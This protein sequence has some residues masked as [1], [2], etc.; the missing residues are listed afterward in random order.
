MNAE[1]PRRK[2]TAILSADVEGYT[3]LIDDDEN[4]TLQTITAYPEVMSGLIRGHDGRVMDSEGD[5][6]VAEFDSIVDAVRCAAKIQ[7]EVRVRNAALS[8]ARQIAFRIGIS[9]GDV[10]RDEKAVYGEVVNIAAGLK[11]LAEGGGICI[12]GKAYQEVKNKLALSYERLGRR[13][14]RNVAEPVTVYRVLMKPGVTGKVVAEK[15]ESPRVWRRIAMATVLL[16]LMG[17]ALAFW[18]FYLRSPPVEIAPVETTKIS[19][20]DKPSI[21]EERRRLEAERKEKSDEFAKE[22]RELE[23]AIQTYE[24]RAKASEESIKALRDRLEEA[25]RKEEEARKRRIEEERRRREEEKRQALKEREERLIR[26]RKLE[27]ERKVLEKNLQEDQAKIVALV[28]KMKR[29]EQELELERK[30]TDVKAR[31]KKDQEALKAIERE[32]RIIQAEVEKS[33][34]T[35]KELEGKKPQKTQLASIPEITREPEIRRIKLRSSPREV[36]DSDI[37]IMITKNNFF[38]RYRND[39]GSFPNDFVDNGDGSVTDRVTGLMWEKGGSSSA[40][41]YQEAQEFVSRLNKEK[42]L[43]HQDWRIPTLEELF[44]L[45]EP[46]LNDKGQYI[47]ALFDSRQATCWSSDRQTFHAGW[48]YYHIADFSSGRV[49]WGGVTTTTTTLFEDWYFVR[50]VRSIHQKEKASVRVQ[51]KRLAYIRKEVKPH[52]IESVKLRSEPEEIQEIDI[53]EMITK[54]GFLS[55]T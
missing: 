53:E 23:E 26:E 33:S 38:V 52:R 44:S 40:I 21:D 45:L 9:L 16:A 32:L 41:R 29:L 47:E 19:R 51:D 20:P 28:E 2:L 46:K 12:S 6:L 43:G 36:W 54:Y 48:S 11:G 17:G 31:S 14:L 4:V 30:R 15:K 49:S 27:E 7:E 22:M 18:N 37:E 55:H 50:A 1:R 5:S 34:Q 39:E 3:R 8:E 10:I 42:Y 24:K 13:S 25:E 35:L